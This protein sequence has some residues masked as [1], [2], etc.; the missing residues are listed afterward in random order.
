MKFVW[1]FQKL[2]QWNGERR[3]FDREA[4]LVINWGL[5]EHVEEIFGW[6]RN[7]AIDLFNLELKF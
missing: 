6:F 2:F 7:F 1:L 5:N 4:N 3:Q